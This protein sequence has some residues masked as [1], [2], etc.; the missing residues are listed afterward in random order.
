MNAYK[1]F[2]IILT[3]CLMMRLAH[4]CCIGD[5]IFYQTAAKNECHKKMEN[6][7]VESTVKRK[8]FFMFHYQ[9]YQNFFFLFSVCYRASTINMVY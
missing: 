9:H 7:V 4:G 6:P 5:D 2:L 1:E 3:S 8:V